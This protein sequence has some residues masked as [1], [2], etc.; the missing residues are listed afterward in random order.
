MLREKK[1]KIRGVLSRIPQWAFTTVTVLAIIWLTLVPD[2]LGDDSPH[3]F[4][5]AD[6][7]VH[8]LMFGGLTSMILLDLQRRSEWRPV[9]K[10]VVWMAALTAASFGILIE[11]LQLWMGLGRGFEIADMV[12]DTAGSAIVAILWLR[13]QIHWSEEDINNNDKIVRR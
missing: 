3:L 4:P 7:V 9:G 10:G 12:A 2:P 13:L 5:G 8:A 1:E 11:F 6:K